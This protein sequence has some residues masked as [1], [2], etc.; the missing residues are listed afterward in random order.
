MPPGADQRARRPTTSTGCVPMNEAAANIPWLPTNEVVAPTVQHLGC[1]PE[2]AELRI[3]GE[4]RGGRIKA[5]GVIK[6]PPESW[7]FPISPIVASDCQAPV[8][9]LPAAWS[10]TIN[11]AGA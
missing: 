8:S 10:G 1:T 7:G 5:W 2:A 9:P 6:G 4:G 11:L 3:I